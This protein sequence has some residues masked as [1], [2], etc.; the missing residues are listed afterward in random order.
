MEC[1]SLA[2]AFAAAQEISNFKFEIWDR[3]PHAQRRTSFSY[4]DVKKK[5]F[6]RVTRGA[7]LTLSLVTCSLSFAGKGFSLCIQ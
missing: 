2:I 1:E 4:I 6:W 7:A 5:V 3:P